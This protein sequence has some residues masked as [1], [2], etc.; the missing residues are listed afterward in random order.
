M[1]RYLGTYI[2]KV[3]YQKSNLCVSYMVT[4]EVQNSANTSNRRCKQKSRGP[5]TKPVDVIYNNYPFNMVWVH[6]Y[7]YVHD[8]IVDN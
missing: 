1:T 4:A 7:I 6:R 8:I 5:P 3:G 2:L